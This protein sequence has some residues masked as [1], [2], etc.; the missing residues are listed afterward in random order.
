MVLKLIIGAACA[1]LTI[2]SSSTYAST[3]YD[4]GTPNQINAHNIGG[5]IAADDFSFTSAT[6]LTGAQIYFSTEL[7]QSDWES[8]RYT[9]SFTYYLYEDSYGK[10]GPLLTVG[11]TQNTTITTSSIPSVG[12]TTLLMTFD[13]VNSFSVMADTTYWLGMESSK[14]FIFWSDTSSTH[15]FT[16]YQR[17]IDGTSLWSQSD[18]DLAYTLSG[19]QVVPV[20]AATW[21]FGSGLIGLIGVARRKKT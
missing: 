10:P 21:L 11:Q 8:N 4:N 2:V 14:N 16:S 9:S 6:T 17:R 19:T 5:F 15:G 12:P 18:T 3:I 13:L 1:C 7:T 20:P